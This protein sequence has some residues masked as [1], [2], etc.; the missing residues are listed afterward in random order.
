MQLQCV[1]G[2][3][4]AVPVF[5]LDGIIGGKGFLSV[6]VRSF[7]EKSTVRFRFLSQARLKDL[8]S[9]F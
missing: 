9:T 7:Q 5:G 1:H 2:M 6:F 8:I 3:V 4:Q